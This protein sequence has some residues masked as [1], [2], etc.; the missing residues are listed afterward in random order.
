MKIENLCGRRYS[1][2]VKCLQGPKV[3]EDTGQ[4]LCVSRTILGGY[5]QPGEGC[6][7]IDVFGGQV[8][9]PIL[10]VSTSLFLDASLMV[11]PVRK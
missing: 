7:V 6:D 1:R 2:R 3:F 9:F 11:L 10:T 4:L 5:P 8:H